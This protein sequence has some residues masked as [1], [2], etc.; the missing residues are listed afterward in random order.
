[1]SNVTMIEN[2]T[3]KNPHSIPGKALW[4]KSLIN[5]VTDPEELWALLDLPKDLL[6][7]AKRVAQLFPLKVTREFIA[8]MIPNHLD[9]PL[10]K[11]VLPIGLEEKIV[12]NYVADPLKEQ[13]AAKVPGL[14]HKYQSRVLLVFSGACAIHCRYCFRRE[15][16]YEE[17]RLNLKSWQPALDYIK[18]NSDIH[19]VIFSGGDPLVVRDAFLKEFLQQLKE[20]PH[21]RRLRIH[22]RLPIVLPSRITPELLDLFDSKRFQW[23]MV[24]HSNHAQELDDSVADAVAKCRQTGMTVLNQTVLLK[25]INNN[26]QT[27][28]ALSERLFEMG[29]LPYYLHLLDP[30]AGA[31]HFDMDER[32]AVQLHQALQ[33]QLPGYLVPKLVREEAGKL[34]KSLIF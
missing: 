5:L 19:E 34:S 28:K 1:M 3:P 26:V 2:S 9:D 22:S 10:L 14:L 33:A 24:I 4:Q 27:L 8:R 15:F 30:V 31:S 16:P 13:L 23:V 18:N 29:V 12:P 20:I 7:D 6:P 21:V 17:H 32:E 25:G 11:Q